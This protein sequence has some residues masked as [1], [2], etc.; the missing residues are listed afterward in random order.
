MLGIVL[1]LLATLLVLSLA[2]RFDNANAKACSWEPLGNPARL[3]KKAR[4]T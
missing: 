3:S 1:T 4:K 2:F